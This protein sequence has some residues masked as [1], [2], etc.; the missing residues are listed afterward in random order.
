MGSTACTYGTRLLEE[1]V[2]GSEGRAE[3][4]WVGDEFGDENPEFCS[5]IEFGQ[6]AEFVHDDVVHQLLRELGDF[7]IKIQISFF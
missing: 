2:L 5:M 4:V 6:V 7:V 1:E 3:G